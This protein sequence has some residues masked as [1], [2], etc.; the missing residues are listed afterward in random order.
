MTKLKLLADDLSNLLFN[1]SDQGDNFSLPL[2]GPIGISTQ[3]DSISHGRG[4][5]T[6]RTVQ[7]GEMLFVIKPQLCAP[8]E[9][10]YQRW[11]TK[12]ARGC[13]ATLEEVAEEVLLDQM[14]ECL[15]VGDEKQIVSLMLQ[16][17]EVK[18][19][20]FKLQ[21][22]PSDIYLDALLGRSSAHKFHLKHDWIQNGSDENLLSIIRRNAFGPDYH[23]YD[24]MG[25]KLNS[26]KGAASVEGTAPY[27]RILG[28]Y[29]L[30]AMINHSCSPNAVRVF[31]GEVMV[32]H[33]CAVIPRGSE[34]VWS[35]IVPNQPYH[36]R[37]NEI[38]S[39]YGF[40][41][42]CCRCKQ[43]ETAYGQVPTLHDQLARFDP[44]NCQSA[45][46]NFTS[47][48]LSR[49]KDDLEG[50]LVN[51]KLSNELKR[52]LRVGY[53]NFYIYYFNLSLA[54]I[55]Q[56]N[57]DSAEI[58]LKVLTLAAQLHFALVACNNACIAHLSILHMAYELAA[59]IARSSVGGNV[60]TKSMVANVQF[61]TEQLKRVH[62]IR[63]GAL[64]QNLEN[65]REVMKHTRLTVR[66]IDGL[67]E[68]QWSF[69]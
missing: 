12:G 19:E 26:K 48:E 2:V 59:I 23:N 66:N 68:A 40:R 5:V 28:L 8:I 58:R 1:C 56:D 29:P 55:E 50:L 32:V 15:Q 30:A 31:V 47:K 3:S 24:T 37:S 20:E 67:S 60:K 51:E 16:L 49:L 69:I 25:K 4:L 22:F 65:T 27:S 6:T 38:Y 10:V 45:S 34:I 63:Y 33:A 36:V 35:Y 11:C 18:D 64:G 44:I 52:Y 62:M 46:L 43:E 7:A 42:C 14:R 54:G 13:R 41:C 57:E 61:W 53:L 21:G 17:G 9:A 39:K